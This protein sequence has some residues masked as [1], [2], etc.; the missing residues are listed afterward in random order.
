MLPT[1]QQVM[2]VSAESSFDTVNGRMN[3]HCAVRMAYSLQC[4][5]HCLVSSIYPFP[6]SWWRSV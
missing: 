5:I 2:I 4:S 1:F 3:P 6:G